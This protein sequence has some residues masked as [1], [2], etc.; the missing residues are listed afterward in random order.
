MSGSLVLASSSTRRR[1]MLAEAG[2]DAMSIA[3]L[4]DDG[5]LIVRADPTSGNCCALAWFKEAQIL[6]EIA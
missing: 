4:V 1:A 5:G 2:F 6:N 3:P